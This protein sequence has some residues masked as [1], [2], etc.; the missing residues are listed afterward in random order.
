MERKGGKRWKGGGAGGREGD[1]KINAL[2]Y[3]SAEG[4]NT[5]PSSPA[6]L[7]RRG[8][9]RRSPTPTRNTAQAGRVWGGETWHHYGAWRTHR[10]A[11]TP[12]DFSQTYTKTQQQILSPLGKDGGG[13]REGGGERRPQ[14]SPQGPD[15]AQL[16][17]PRLAPPQAGVCARVSPRPCE[18][19][20]AGPRGCAAG[21]LPAGCR[22]EAASASTA[23]PLGRG[24]GPLLRR[25]R[26]LGQAARRRAWRAHQPRD[27]AEGDT[28]AAAASAAAALPP[29]LPPSPPASAPPSPSPPQQERGRAA[30][31][32]ES[33]VGGWA[34]PLPLRRRHRWGRA[35]SGPLAS[36]NAEQ[37]PRRRGARP[38]LSPPAPH[39]G[40]CFTGEAGGR[41]AGRGRRCGGSPRGGGTGAGGEQ[42]PAV[43]AAPGALGR[44]T[45]T[46]GPPGRAVKATGKRAYSP[47]RFSLPI[48]GKPRWK[49]YRVFRR[50][51]AST[52]GKEYGSHAY[53]YAR[54]TLS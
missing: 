6:R 27:V 3:L 42:P 44:V 29:A 39:G 15:L 8:E 18:R 54:L 26:R 34:D 51:L 37:R 22:G 31:A 49:I 43:S 14:A 9:Q 7:P 25:R 23:P 48:L 53:P 19:A 1:G 4:T 47:A 21:Q 5:A 30:G 12:P 11:P 2:C 17:H 32:G 45:E 41:A 36:L 52:E 10:S 28:A 33:A 50:L 38:P 13:G 20:D 35:G 46:C 16:H 40:L 24:A